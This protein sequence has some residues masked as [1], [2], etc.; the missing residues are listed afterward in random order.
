MRIYVN[1]QC[2]YQCL[3]ISLSFICVFI[4]H[5]S[6]YLRVYAWLYSAMFTVPGCILQDFWYDTMQLFHSSL[7]LYLPVS[8]SAC[9]FFTFGCEKVADCASA[10]ERLHI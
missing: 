6:L 5:Y 7:H 3:T 9:T 10:V 8:H 4:Q 1:D 2:I